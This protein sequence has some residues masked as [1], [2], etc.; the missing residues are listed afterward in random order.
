M[1]PKPT[2]AHR[3]PA[4]YIP[5]DLADA[6][7]VFVRRGGVQPSFAS[8]YE[9]PYRVAERTNAG[10]RVLLPGGRI[11]TVALCRL[12][13][14]HIDVD[15]ILEDPEQNLD[16]A[17]PP[18]PRPP[19]R[20]PGVRT[21]TPQ[22]TDRVTRQSRQRS[23][24]QPRTTPG[25][26]TPNNRPNQP[27]AQPDENIG[28]GTPNNRPM[29]SQPPAPSRPTDIAPSSVGSDP[30]TSSRLS[31]RVPVNLRRRQQNVASDS[32]ARP[33]RPVPTASSDVRRPTP[34]I[35]EFNRVPVEP[36]AQLRTE[37]YRSESLHADE[38]EP[39]NQP[40]LFELG[41]IRDA[42][43][44]RLAPDPGPLPAT[45]YNS[46]QSAE[47]SS[48][49]HQVDPP[50]DPTTL[51]ATAAP[52]IR[53][54]STH[55]QGQEGRR[56]FSDVRPKGN[57]SRLRP[58]VSAIYDHLG[59]L[60][61]SE[62]SSPLHSASASS[63]GGRVESARPPPHPSAAPRHVPSSSYSSVVLSES[64]PPPITHRESS[65][66]LPVYTVLPE[67]IH[68]S[69]TTAESSE[70]QGLSSSLPSSSVISYT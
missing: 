57:S 62:A 4:V 48:S 14:A 58:D 26:G 8:P 65:S 49:R 23:A 47:R 56:F 38:D 17:R 44:G 5:P 32:G 6:T 30:P 55:R 31:S 10:Y 33:R 16:D 19:G 61:D 52:P 67:R 41:D 42:L 43:A 53:F 3:R 21:R 35:A 70:P 50:V 13:P 15:D 18:S 60:T 25:D 54:S 11:E 20:P 2:S 34:H 59:I 29:S 63:A 45:S 7:H 28:D 39:S 69:T 1:L 51:G 24:A 36:S 64:I 22:A 37:A 68:P 46:N 12:K 40:S 27:S 9:G 66:P